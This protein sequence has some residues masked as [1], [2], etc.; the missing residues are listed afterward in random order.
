MLPEIT[1]QAYQFVAT[2]MKMH[3][4]NDDTAADTRNPERVTVSVGSGR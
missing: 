4:W 1:T 3:N 2:V